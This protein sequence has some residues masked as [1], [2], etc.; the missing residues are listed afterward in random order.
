MARLEAPERLGEGRPSGAPRPSS[1]P[2]QASRALRAGAPSHASRSQAA[3]GLH[4]WRERH[5]GWLGPGRPG[6][7]AGQRSGQARVGRGSA[8]RRDAAT[9]RRSSPAATARTSASRSGGGGVSSTSRPARAG[10][11]RPPPRS[12]RNRRTAASTALTASARSSSLLAAAS[13]GREPRRVVV[14]GVEPALRCRGEHVHC[15]Q[16]RPGRRSSAERRHPAA[17]RRDGLP[18]HRREP[19][20]RVGPPPFDISA[21][22]GRA[23]RRH[24]HRCARIL[25][26]K[27]DLTPV[28]TPRRPERPAVPGRAVPSRIPRWPGRPGRGAAPALPGARGARGLRAERRLSFVHTHTGERLSTTYWGDGAYSTSEL[29]RVQDFLRDFRTGERHAIDPALLDQ[30]HDHLPGDRDRCSVP[31]DQRLSLSPHQCVAAR[32]GRRP[33]WPQPPHARTGRRRATRRR[34]ERVDP[35][36]GPPAR[37]RRCGL[38]PGRG[39]RAPRH[40][41]HPS[42]VAGRWEEGVDALPGRVQPLSMSREGAHLAPGR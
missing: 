4:S 29:G 11:T 10:S 3:P 23:S 15:A 35:R 30:L 1:S 37:S 12:P 18:P 36:R 31:G 2:S 5:A 17:S 42:L 38:L 25:S 24:R 26:G 34:L 39:L 6:A 32:R 7:P 27:D 40:R 41:A 21:L 19:P 20:T 8:A 22:R 9:E 13:A 28:A 16:Q 14:G 33:G